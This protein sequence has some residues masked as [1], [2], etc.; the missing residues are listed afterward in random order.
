MTWLADPSIWIGLFTLVVLEIVLG[1]DN[2]VFIAILVNKLPPAQ[3]DRARMIGLGL[4]LGMRVVLLMAMSWLIGLTKPLLTIGPVDLSGRSIILLLGGFFLLFKATSELHERLDGEPQDESHGTGHG[5]FWNVIAQVVIL[6]AVFS[7]DSVIT[8]VGMVND[9]P[10][11]IAAVVIAMGAMLFASRPLTNFVNAHRTVVVL[12]LSFLLMIGFSLVAEGLGFHIPKGYLY[13]AIGFSILI[14]FFNQVAQRNTVRYERRRPLRE[15]TAD[16][17]LSLLGD[18]R[19]TPADTEAHETAPHADQPAPETVFRPEERSMVSGV[20]DLAERSVRSIMTPRHDISWVDLDA[21]P[22]TTRKLLLAVPH[23]QFPVCRGGL[24]DLVGVARAKDLMGD[25]DTRGTIDVERSVKPALK[26][27]DNI[28]IL[29]LMD[30]LKRARG[31]MMVVTDSLDV[32]QG[33]VTPID[34]LEAIA[35][36]FPDEDERLG[37]VEVGEGC[38]E[39]AG[40]ADLRQLE[41]VLHVDWLLD[42]GGGATSLGG[43]LFNQWDRLPE[44]GD[45]LVR[46]DLRFVVLE[47]GSRRIVRVRIERMEEVTAPDAEA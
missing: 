6:D 22:A 8:A 36:E 27:G 34:V 3:R 43:Y 40:E 47:A 7:I 41:D 21:D 29:R 2:L 12:C 44:V 30:K 37:V 9:L 11:M 46:H 5:K 38:W 16:A 35:G 31:R 1:I 20:L 33:V 17:V 13:A 23:N 42:E 15:R 26:V 19:G 24:D 4:A 10:V 32:I 25:L 45:S 18:R 39:V 28:G 14:E